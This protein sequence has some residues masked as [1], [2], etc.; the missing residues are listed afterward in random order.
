MPDT[1]A[2]VDR[3]LT[4]EVV[5]LVREAGELTLR[6]FRS[7]TL[8]VQRKGDGTPVTVVTRSFMGLSQLTR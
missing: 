6:W 4:D 5:E 7:S 1:A 3:R 2:P 8:D